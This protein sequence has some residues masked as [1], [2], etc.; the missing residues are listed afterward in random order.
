[1]VLLRGLRSTEDGEDKV[2]NPQRI[3]V[4]CPGG[5]TILRARDPWGPLASFV[6]WLAPSPKQFSTV[7]PNLLEWEGHVFLGGD[8]KF[9]SW[10]ERPQE[11][12]EAGQGREQRL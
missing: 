12:E 9:S 4:L 2:V 7:T 3:L 6:E 11:G 10:G 5:K 1:M 8:L